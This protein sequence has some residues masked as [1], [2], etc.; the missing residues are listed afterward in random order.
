M[1]VHERQ[2]EPA[3]TQGIGGGGTRAARTNNNNV[4]L[5]DHA[6]TNS[7]AIGLTHSDIA[8]ADII[9]IACGAA[10]PLSRLPLLTDAVEKWVERAGEQ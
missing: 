6:E 3:F 7:Q 4:C 2:A 10:C 9:I 1:L 5:A 8:P